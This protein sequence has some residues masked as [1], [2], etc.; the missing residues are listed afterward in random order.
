MIDRA[1]AL[2]LLV[3]LACLAAHVISLVVGGVLA[4]GLDPVASALQGVLAR[5]NS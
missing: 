3:I 2:V 4:A 5:Q 1:V